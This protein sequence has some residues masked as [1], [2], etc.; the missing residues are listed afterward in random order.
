M[1]MRSIGAAL[2]ALS[3]SPALQAADKPLLQD[4]KKTLFQRVLTTP[5]CKL[6]D[7]AGAAPGAA[8][9]TFSRFYVYERAQLTPASGCGSALTPRARASAGC[10]PIAP[11]NGKCS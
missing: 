5:G 8:Q 2:L 9:P 11:S 4:G 7:N 3:L 10:L 1:K 6:S